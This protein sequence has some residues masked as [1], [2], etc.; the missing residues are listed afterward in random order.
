VGL[1][2]SFTL[3]SCFHRCSLLQIPTP[4]RPVDHRARFN[5]WNLDER[6]VEPETEWN[7]SSYDV[8]EVPTTPQPG[9]RPIVALYGAPGD[10]VA[11]QFVERSGAIVGANVVVGGGAPV[12]GLVDGIAHAAVVLVNAQYANVVAVPSL[13]V[14]NGKETAVVIGADDSVVDAAVGKNIVH[15]A[16]G[17]VLSVDG[18]SAMWNGVVGA[19]V[20]SSGAVPTVSVGGKAAVALAPV[21]LAFPAKRIVFYEKGGKSGSISEDDAV[22]RIVALTDE[23]KAAVAAAIVKGA[24]LSVT[25]SAAD[26]VAL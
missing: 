15:G 3:P 4:P 14:S 8:R 10:A 26:A 23:S 19:P 21:N 17:N 25:G 7:G 16:Y 24:K 5:G 13:S 1:P 11:V 9:Q 12:R 20:K 22:K 18:V 2:R 6:W